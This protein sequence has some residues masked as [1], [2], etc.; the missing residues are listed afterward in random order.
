MKRRKT[1]LVLAT[2]V[3]VSLLPATA[4]ADA[5][6]Q[7][8]FFEHDVLIRT[9]W[10]I[11]AG[12]AIEYPVVNWMIKQNRLKA[13]IATIVMNL[14]S[15][16]FGAFLQAP[17]MS[18]RGSSSVVYVFAVAILGNTLIEGVVLNRF[19]RKVFNRHTFLPL[20]GVNALSVG[21]TIG[22]LFYCVDS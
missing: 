5:V 21:L 15:F 18:M 6:W 2:L 4:R 7:A 20:L 13:A 17:A 10:V 12:L 22:V 8:L 14:V 9:W 19:R 3:A 1:C 11:P 16:F